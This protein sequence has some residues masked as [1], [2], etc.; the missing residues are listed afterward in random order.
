MKEEVEVLDT[1]RQVDQ[2]MEMVE[3]DKMDIDTKERKTTLQLL[4]IL[5][6]GNLDLDVFIH[7]CL[8]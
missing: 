1:L 2:V 4:L 7:Q 5:I 6:R 3:E 8:F